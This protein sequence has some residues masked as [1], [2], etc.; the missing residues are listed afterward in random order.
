MQV[1]VIVP[2]P[3]PLGLV[4][5]HWHPAAYWIGNVWDEVCYTVPATPESEVSKAW[6]QGPPTCPF[7]ITEW[8]LWGLRTWKVIRSPSGVYSPPR[9]GKEAKKLS[10]TQPNAETSTRLWHHHLCL[11]ESFEKSKLLFRWLLLCLSMGQEHQRKS[12]FI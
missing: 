1:A 2:V 6:G 11:Q 7:P 12:K 4:R 9:K 3:H 8:A 10:V 5:K